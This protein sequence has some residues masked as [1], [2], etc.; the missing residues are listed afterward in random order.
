MYT[1]GPSYLDPT[2]R[3]GKQPEGSVMDSLHRPFHKRRELVRRTKSD[4]NESRRVP[5]DTVQCSFFIG[6]LFVLYSAIVCLY[7]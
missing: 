7:G 5:A 2:D 4:V 6:Q 1:W 3:S